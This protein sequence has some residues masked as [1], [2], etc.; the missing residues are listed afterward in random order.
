[1]S[2]YDYT[3]MSAEAFNRMMMGTGQSYTSMYNNVNNASGSGNTP[4]W[5]SNKQKY[6]TEDEF[7]NGFQNV[8]DYYSEMEKI[9]GKL[10]GT[11][12][13]KPP[14]KPS[15]VGQG[16]N[17]SSPVNMPNASPRGFS[18]LQLNTTANDDFAQG[19]LNSPLLNKGLLK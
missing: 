19:L 7:Y 8:D 13:E 6:I 15:G 16:S 2:T 1:M 14:F 18:P 17:V 3:V 4:Y 10:E 9:R 12:D 11:E 5:D